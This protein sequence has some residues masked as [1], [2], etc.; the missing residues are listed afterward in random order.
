MVTAEDDST[1]SALLGF[2]E[3]SSPLHQV[4]LVLCVELH[5]GVYLVL[6]DGSTA[7]IFEEVFPTSIDILMFNIVV[8]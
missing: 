2:S 3:V 7:A 8:V 4:V 5:F 1:W 6:N